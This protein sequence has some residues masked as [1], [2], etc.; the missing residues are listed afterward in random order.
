LWQQKTALMRFLFLLLLIPVT[1]QA[2]ETFAPLAKPLQIPIFIAKKADLR[3]DG[4]LDEADWSHAQEAGQFV[5]IEPNQGQKSGF[6]TSVKILAG[7]K[8]L[9]LGITCYDTVGKKMYRTPDLKRDFAWRSFDMVAIGIDGFHDRRNSMTFATNA[10]GAQKDYLSFDDLLFD[11][12]WNGL[13]SVRTTRSDSNWVAEFSIP[14]KTLRYA[15]S[16]SIQNWGLNLLRLRRN[17][18]EI[19]AWSPYPRVFGFNRMDY[20]GELTGIL[21]PK[22]GANVQVNPYTLFTR[23]KTQEKDA[24]NQLKIGAELKWAIN[25]SS[26][27]DLTYNT[28]FA[29]TDADIQ[30]NNLSRFSVF[31]PEKRQ[32]FLE[33]GSLF[34]ANL[35]PDGRDHSGGDMIIQPF[36]S[37]SIGLDQAGNPIPIDFGARYINCSIQQSVGG[38]LIR[39][40][41]SDKSPATTFGV[42][43]Y[44]RFVGKQNRLGGMVVMNAKSALGEKAGYTNMVGMLDGFFRLSAAKTLDFM[45][46]PSANTNGSGQGLSSFVRYLYNTNQLKFWWVQSMVSKDYSPETGFVSRNDVLGTNAGAYVYVRDKKLPEALRAYE[47]AIFMGF[48]HQ[49]S[50]QKLIERNISLIPL[51]LNLQ[52]GGLL[53]VTVNHSYQVLNE[54]FSP[55]GV[56]IGPGAYDY[57]RFGAVLANNPS[58][59]VTYRVKHEWGNF[60]DGQLQTSDLQLGYNPI[61]NLAFRFRFTSNQ[62]K[63]VGIAQTD[64]RI[65]LLNLESRL[66][67]NPRV[68]LVGLFQHNTQ[69]NFNA[70][71]IRFAWEYKPLSFIYLIWNNRSFE[72]LDASGA[73]IRNADDAIFSKISW[74]KQF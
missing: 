35:E 26:V 36:F 24:E 7:A 48:Y 59:R 31:F 74:L 50:T 5:Q 4:K 63:N 3:L 42:A 62:F 45:V 69:N 70:Y 46:T 18:N 28:D 41:E 40:H 23:Q 6:K 13:W 8:N 12:D 2:Q 64:T 54:N 17:S 44:S 68:Q 57:L 49:L 9:Y 37:R 56:K 53:Q 16:D 1:C 25:Q 43:R 14:W 47:P 33:N 22:S 71:N 32:F 73:S 11:G 58:R 21:P 60:F 52:S 30:V 39:Q 51:G 67:L 15:P 34:A 66:A 27:L 55:L 10:Y 19:S 20:A 61:P 65:N 38:M 29:Q 72:N